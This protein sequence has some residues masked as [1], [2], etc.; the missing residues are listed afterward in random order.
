M[1]YILFDSGSRVKEII[2]AEDPV[3]PGIPIEQRYAPDFVAQL[4]ET[5][6]GT[7]VEQN[8]IYDRETGTFAPPP[9]PE[10]VP[11]D[12][13]AEVVDDGT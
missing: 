13:G 6:D 10:Q 4:M 1:K 12:E 3:F 11:E 7:E 8:W 9:V 2:P 5:A